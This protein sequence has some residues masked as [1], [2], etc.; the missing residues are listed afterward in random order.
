MHNPNAFYLLLDSAPQRTVLLV[1]AQLTTTLFVQRNILDTRLVSVTL[2]QAQE[3]LL[4]D[5]P[6]GSYYSL[7]KGVVTAQETA[8]VS[9]IIKKKA[10]RARLL[11]E[12]YGYLTW[13]ANMA[14]E[15]YWATSS[16][17]FA[18][19]LLLSKRREEVINL[20]ATTKRMSYAEAEKQ[21]AF[22]EDNLL[23]L[24]MRRKQIIWLYEETLMSVS[25]V[26][27]LETWKASVKNDTIDVGAV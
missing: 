6:K 27:E 4:P 19:T 9:D 3:S 15:A 26:A 24:A 7:K 10:A 2:A 23:T 8:D 13:F 1:G 11:S 18:D 21:I 20:F 5:M 12:G 14:T 22:D 16:I 25:S 17:D